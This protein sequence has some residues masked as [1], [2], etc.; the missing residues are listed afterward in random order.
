MIGS[1]GVERDGLS[2]VARM[3]VLYRLEHERV[4]RLCRA[5]LGN[6]DDAEEATQEA[7]LRVAPRLASLQG[8]PAAYLSVVARRVCWEMRK[9]SSRTVS[10]DAMGEFGT[11]G[12]ESGV[13]ARQQ[14]DAAWKQLSATDRRL[15]FG[16]YAG[17]SQAEISARTGISAGAIA[18]GLH[19]ARR[20]ARILADR[21]T[22]WVPP[23]QGLGARLRF[24]R[25]VRRGDDQRYVAPVQILAIRVFAGVAVGLVLV[26]SGAPRRPAGHPAAGLPVSPPPA[27]MV[28]V[29]GVTGAR[30][31]QPPPRVAGG[32]SPPRSRPLVPTIPG[33]LDPGQNSQ[34]ED[35]AVIR[36]AV[37][38][39]YSRD[40]TVFASALLVDGCS[41]I[42]C[43]VLYASHDGGTTW[44]ALAGSPPGSQFP[45]GTVLLPPSYPTDSTIFAMGPTALY[46][47]T[48][49]GSTF[50]PALVV[51]GV[52][53]VDPVSKP[54]AAQLLA[55][56]QALMRYQFDKR[57]ATPEPLIFQ[58]VNGPVQMLYAPGAEQ[59]ITSTE[60][61]DQ[62][63]PRAYD[64]LISA[65]PSMGQCRELL[66]V[67]LAGA[68]FATVAPG[69][70]GQPGS[71]L[72]Y[73]GD[74]LW[75]AD[76]TTLVFRRLALPLAGYLSAVA[77][78]AGGRVVT[79]SMVTDGDSLNPI[80]A[81]SNDGGGSWTWSRPPE[82]RGVG[83][84]VPMTYLPDGRLLGAVTVDW[85]TGD[86]F[87][88]ACSR[89]GGASWTKRC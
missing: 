66:R 30:A 48:D 83:P 70:G 13:V 37:S 77:A 16:T 33:L 56:G 45:G 75:V 64:G 67:A 7:F 19:R 86:R 89:D 34:P 38:P 39:N 24:R 11:E 49:G 5:V 72:A 69:V 84:I 79:V 87:G 74:G 44:K 78:E 23:L 35:A 42:S 68:M 2:G 76:S 63:N 12:P 21:L 26:T 59:L 31:S 51:N 10:I 53:V 65:C 62:A 81:R 73:S 20:R 54:G 43:P 80:I 28:A 71:V 14:L 17:F 88:M 3:E 9:K 46:Q 8:E 60:M 50:Q 36:L 41:L 29:A 4:M 22:A 47:S 15:I 58:S 40:R 18:V 57:A 1:E 32:W 61:P 85:K 55:G 27:G 25:T 6:Q 82:L 52:A